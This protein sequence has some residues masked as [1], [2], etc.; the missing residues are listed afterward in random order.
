MTSAL[1]DLGYCKGQAGEV[2]TDLFR[3]I[4]EALVRGESVRVY[5]FG[6]FEVKTHKGRLAHNVATGENRVL[7]DYP[8]VSFRPGENLKE[9]VKSGDLGKLAKQEK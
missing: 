2:I 6:T 1:S 7:P 9:A 8:V 3:I 4:S 5:G